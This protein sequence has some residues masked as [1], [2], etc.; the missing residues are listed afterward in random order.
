MSEG[1]KPSNILKKVII[2]A[3]G[4]CDKKKT[5]TKKKKEKKDEAGSQQALNLFSSHEMSE[6]RLAY[7]KVA[8]VYPSC[9]KCGNWID[10]EI[11]RHHTVPVIMLH[12]ILFWLLKAYFKSEPGKEV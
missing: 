6:A 2:F 5:K 7:G 10:T 8:C 1:W 9:V 12:L 4:I 3:P 11:E